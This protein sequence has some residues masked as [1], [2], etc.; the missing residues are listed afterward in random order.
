MIIVN[1][2]MI[3]GDPDLHVGS[4]CQFPVLLSFNCSCLIS[5]WNTQVKEVKEK[6]H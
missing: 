1:G 5:D 3:V 6:R 4:D 2:W